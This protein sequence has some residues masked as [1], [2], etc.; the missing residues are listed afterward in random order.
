MR[1][2]EATIGRIRAALAGACGELPVRLVVLFG[3]QADGR[4]RPDSDVDVAVQL[5]PGGKWDHAFRAAGLVEDVARAEVD[6]VV[7]NEAGAT[8]LLNVA[9]DGIPLFEARVGDWRRFWHA[10]Y[11]MYEEAA[12]VRAMQNAI[13]Q[14]RWGVTV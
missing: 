9:A 5:M 14:R 13:L 6:V 7:L 3:S 2:D 4:A 1:M 8:L 12:P 10:A 11:R